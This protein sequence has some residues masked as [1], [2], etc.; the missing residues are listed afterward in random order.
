MGT[1]ITIEDDRKGVEEDYFVGRETETSV[2][3]SATSRDS[4]FSQFTQ[5]TSRN[6]SSAPLPITS[7]EKKPK[8]LGERYGVCRIKDCKNKA[9]GSDGHCFNHSSNKKSHL[10]RESK[11]A[12][13]MARTSLDFV[14]I[15]C[16]ENSFKFQPRKDDWPN[17]GPKSLIERFKRQERMELGEA[18]ALIDRARDV[19][20]R[21]PNVLKLEAPV[22]AVGDVHGQFYDLL[23]MFDVGGD[24]MTSSSRYLFLGDYVDRGSFSCEVILSLLAY[25]VAC[26]HNIWLIRGNVSH[27]NT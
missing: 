26:P 14:Q 3:S 1:P 6:S 16:N 11:L 4:L 18:M 10:V 20:R 22:I 15:N 25:K 7:P 21:E 13:I 23:N 5:R 27:V 17:V 8:G 19:L 9:C 2:N 12:N 24:P